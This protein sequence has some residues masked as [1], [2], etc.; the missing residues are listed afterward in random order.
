E[1]VKALLAS[2]ADVNAQTKQ[3]VTALMTAA[4]NGHVEVVK[5]LLAG[6]ADLNV[7]DIYCKKAIDYATDKKEI[8]ELLK[9]QMQKSV[10][11][12]K[13]SSGSTVLA[14]AG[15]GVA[16]AGGGAGQNIS[17]TL[18]TEVAAKILAEA[19]TQTEPIQVEPIQAAAQKRLLSSRLKSAFSKPSLSEKPSSAS[20]MAC[21]EASGGIVV[22]IAVRP[23][24]TGFACLQPNIAPHVFS[25]QPLILEARANGTGLSGLIKLLNSYADDAFDASEA[26]SLVRSLGFNAS[27]FEQAH[28]K[29]I[30][31]LQLA[32]LLTDRISSI[33]GPEDAASVIT[34]DQATN[35]QILETLFE[36]LP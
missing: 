6:G 35:F 36:H 3:G 18:C 16:R 20:Q 26:E 22:P 15:G 30:T 17:K 34:E 27:I 21:D 1:V 23:G 8:I 7:E 24:A 9:K 4:Y 10:K 28:Y 14:S 19:G 13:A 5:A 31:G 32:L 33:L 12:K 25:L 2:G 29:P 11:D